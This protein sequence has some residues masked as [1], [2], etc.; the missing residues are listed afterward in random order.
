MTE[1]EIP[2][3]VVKASV[4]DEESDNELEEPQETTIKD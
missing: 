3:C 4:L 2:A 1:E